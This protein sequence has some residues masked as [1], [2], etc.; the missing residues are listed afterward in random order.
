VNVL[1]PVY[2]KMRERSCLERFNWEATA[3]LF[4][5]RAYQKGNGHLPSSLEELVPRYLSKV[6]IDPFD[7]K[8]LRYSREK[9]IIYCVGTD[10]VDNGGSV[11][12]KVYW[13]D[14][15]DPTIEIGF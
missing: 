14:R 11:G 10:L 1:A 2:S 4:A 9:K 13:T 15:K 5:L 3:C 6:P 7:G 12:E 8:P